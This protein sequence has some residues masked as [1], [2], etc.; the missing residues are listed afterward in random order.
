MS[1]SDEEDGDDGGGAREEGRTSMH[2][3]DPTS[4]GRKGRT[5]TATWTELGGGSLMDGGAG[6]TR[7]RSGREP[8]E[9]G[10]VSG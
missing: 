6:M 4:R 3:S 7:G 8:L 5:R 1:G 9:S 10:Y 2:R